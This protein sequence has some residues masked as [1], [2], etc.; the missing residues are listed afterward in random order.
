[1]NSIDKNIF[2]SYETVETVFRNELATEA[3]FK[4][5]KARTLK[6]EGYYIKYDGVCYDI[7]P[8][9]CR[10][11]NLLINNYNMFVEFLNSAKSDVLGFWRMTHGEKLPA[12][13]A[14]MEKALEICQKYLDAFESYITEE[15]EDETSEEVEVTSDESV[16]EEEEDETSEEV[17]VTSD[18]S[19]D[20]EEEDA[21]SNFGRESYKEARNQECLTAPP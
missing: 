15:E 17:K 8:E 2:K 18:E 1:M 6:G 9:Q 10:I 5:K 20:E 3:K 11:Y 7:T 16:D 19:V 21:Q 14:R 4:G 12:D 13:I